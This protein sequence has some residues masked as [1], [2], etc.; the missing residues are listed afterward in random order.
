MASAPAATGLAIDPSGRE[1]QLHEDLAFT[2][3][4]GTASPVYVILQ[5]AERLVDPV[6]AADDEPTKGSNIEEGCRVV[7]AGSP[8]DDGVAVA[9]LVNQQ[10][11]W[12]IDALFVPARSR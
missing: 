2:V 6:P 8:C 4:P 11:T 9:R 12:R 7:L 10:N 3:T 1:I 5:Y